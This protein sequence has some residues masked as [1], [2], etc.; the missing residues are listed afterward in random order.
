M[1]LDIFSLTGSVITPKTLY[2][3]KEIEIFIFATPKDERIKIITTIPKTSLIINKLFKK[4]PKND[5]TAF[6]TRGREVG[7]IAFMEDM[8]I[9]SV[10]Y[11]IYPCTEK[12]M[13]TIMIKADKIKRVPFFMA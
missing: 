6:P 7:D 3:I 1:S 11:N 2:T 10:L 4:T 8:K 12:F 13:T 9:L 5:E